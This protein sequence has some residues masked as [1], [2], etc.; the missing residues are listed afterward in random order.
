MIKDTDLSDQRDYTLNIENERGVQEGIVKLKVV[1]P[2]SA[3]LL[4]AT[5]LSIIIVF[6]V[7]GVV[8]LMFVRR[9]RKGDDSVKDEEAKE[10]AQGK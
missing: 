4:I 6:F 5:F 2:L 9:K 1:T 3:T 7:I 10:D 8:T